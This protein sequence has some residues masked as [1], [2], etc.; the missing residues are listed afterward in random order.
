MA[1]ETRD[2]S[3]DSQHRITTVKSPTAPETY[4]YDDLGNR[5][6]NNAQFDQANRI[7]GDNDFS[8]TYDI[9]GN[10]TQ[11]THTATGATEHY[12]Y[13]GLNQLTRYQSFPDNNPASTAIKDYSYTYGPLGRRWSKHNNLGTELT[14]F[15]WSGSNLIA[16]NHNGTP[17][18]YIL[19]GLTPAGF[20]EN[21]ETYHYL[22]D[23]LG[24]AHEIIDSSGTIVW[25][26]DYRSF[27]A[28]M[29][30]VSLL[31]NHLRF[32]GQYFDTESGLH[33]NYFRDYDPAIGRY[34]Q[35]DPI[36]LRGGLNTYVFVENN[37]IISTDFWGLTTLRCARKLGNKNNPSMSP[38]GNP[39]RHDYLAVDGEV[40]SFQA[41]DNYIWSD[42]K[43]SKDENKSN[44]QCI[45]VSDDPKFDDAVK[46]AVSEVGEPKY[47][48]F[49]YPYTTPY[50]LGARNCQ[51]WVDDILD[52]ARKIRSKE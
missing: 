21:G 18:R 11:K 48:F 47:N 23:H 33:Y 17:R 44:D 37:P 34:L 25:Q 13:N 36:E 14:Q 32:A 3:Y 6:N 9:N 52:K 35:S 30:T 12:T 19:E 4:S 2:Y 8:Y 49:A 43:V 7:T 27:G 39:L 28:V 31:N 51:S 26:G 16:E 41:G 10:R 15:Y 20:I 45:V 5:Q 24:T 22:K 38:S 50:I 46:Q 1:D 42:G 40:F 29:E